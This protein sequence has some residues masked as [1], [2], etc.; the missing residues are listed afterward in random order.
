MKRLAYLVTALLVSC[1]IG[2]AEK[3][4]VIVIMADDIGYGWAATSAEKWDGVPLRSTIC[5]GVC[6]LPLAIIE[7]S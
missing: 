3:T 6:G 5:T 4:N 7:K 1:T 2:A